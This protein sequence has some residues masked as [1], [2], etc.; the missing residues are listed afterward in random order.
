MTKL[1]I[2]TLGLQKYSH[3][4]HA[5]ST[6]VDKRKY[7]EYVLEDSLDLCAKISKIAAIAFVNSY[8]KGG[9]PTADLNLDY[10]ANFANMMGF[11]N[12]EFHELMRL[13]L[14]IHADHEGGNVSA[15]ATQL[16]SSALSDP[17][18]A[19]SAGMNGLA[20][21]LHGL[22]NQEVLKWIEAYVDKYGTST[23]EKDIAS[24][25]N[26]TMASGKVV[27][28]FGHAVLRQ[29]DPRYTS[30]Q[31]FADRYLP[32]DPLYQV[33]KACYKVIPEELK[34]TGKIKN[35][36]PNVDAHSGVLLQHY[37][38]KQVD[39]YTVSII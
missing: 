10:S 3:F 35:P 13:Y 29:T 15:H 11:T 22:A 4:H 18:L 33:V 24:F 36:W 37:G 12:P 38:M 8:G 17:Y 6:G 32:N 34:K 7:W 14:T 25:V 9:V 1:S 27:P 31:R 23:S 30:Q 28:G 16:V 19:F 2:G 5:Y 21:P 26:E 20:G 39:F